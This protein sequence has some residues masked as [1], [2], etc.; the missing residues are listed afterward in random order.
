MWSLLLARIP[1][2]KENTDWVAAADSV[3]VLFHVLTKST[4]V[5]NLYDLHAH[6]VQCLDGLVDGTMVL[7][8]ICVLVPDVWKWW[9]VL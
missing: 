1:Y 4:G 8:I 5:A 9:L 7:I 2:M 3:L 6:A